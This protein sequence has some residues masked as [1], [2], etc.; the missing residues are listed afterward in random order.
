V[1]FIDHISKL[2]RDRVVKKFAKAQKLAKS[3]A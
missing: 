1:L 2:K 3:G